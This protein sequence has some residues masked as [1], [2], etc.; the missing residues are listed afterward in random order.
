LD[1]LWFLK[2]LLYKMRRMCQIGIKTGKCFFLNN[3]QDA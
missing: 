3:F 1:E 2:W